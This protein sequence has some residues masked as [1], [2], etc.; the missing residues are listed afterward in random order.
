MTARKETNLE[1]PVVS[2]N[3]SQVK[4]QSRPRKSSN[5]D[6]R[7]FR[8]LDLSAELRNNIYDK[9]IE[10][11]ALV[12]RRSNFNRNLASTSALVRVSKSIRSEFLPLALETTPIIKTVARDWEFG[13]VV[14]F[15]NS[16]RDHEL[17]RL[18]LEQRM[19]IDLCFSGENADPS[20]LM[21]WID[22]FDDDRRGDGIAFEYVCTDFQISH[23][24]WATAGFRACTTGGP[25][26]SRQFDKIAEVFRSKES[27]SR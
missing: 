19:V 7:H 9:I 18:I 8:F 15:M 1:K 16:L 11:S 2:Q 26:G 12:F 21:R 13:H 22:R 5:K 24:N 4:N 10:E 20:G 27:V 3:E 17:E 6:Q 14:R 25:K 23:Q